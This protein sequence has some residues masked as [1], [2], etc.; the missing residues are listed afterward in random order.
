MHSQLSLGIAK[1]EDQ[2]IVQIIGVPVSSE[3]FALRAVAECHQDG[4]RGR[5]KW[6]EVALKD[7]SGTLQEG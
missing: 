1:K 6:F 4:R 5:G 7:L 2:K 3:T